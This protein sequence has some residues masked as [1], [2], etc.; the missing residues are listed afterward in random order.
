MLKRKVS[1]LVQEEQ[2]ETFP[3]TLGKALSRATEWNASDEEKSQARIDIAIDIVRG[4]IPLESQWEKSLQDIKAD[5]SSH[6]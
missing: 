3:G 1:R 4:W 6:E 5:L 2:F